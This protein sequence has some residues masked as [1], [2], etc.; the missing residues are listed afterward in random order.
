MRLDRPK[1]HE[2]LGRSHLKDQQKAKLF[3]LTILI[4]IT[5]TILSSLLRLTKSRFW[6]LQNPEARDSPGVSLDLILVLLGLLEPG[7]ELCAGLDGHPLALLLRGVVVLLPRLETVLTD[8]VVIVEFLEY[9]VEQ[10]VGVLQSVH[11]VLEGEE[12]L[13]LQPAARVHVQLQ[14]L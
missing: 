3:T 5:I 2:D 9:R 10:L 4:L 6:S 14:D 12:H 11:E 13:Q 1:D 7:E 8:H